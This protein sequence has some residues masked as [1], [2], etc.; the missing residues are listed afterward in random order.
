LYQNLPSATI[1]TAMVKYLF[2]FLLI[3]FIQHKAM[4]QKRTPKIVFVIADG[5]PADLIEKSHKPNFNKIIAN[6]FYKRA[7]VGGIK[8]AYNQ[9]PTV[10][11]PG[12]NNLLT[13]TWAN[14]HQVV[15]NNIKKS[16]LS[17]LFLFSIF[18]RKYPNKTDGSFFNL[19]RQ[20]N[21]INWG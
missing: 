18:K 11:A 1:F 3:S 17:V 4:A 12:Y 7:F 10:S 6:G 20:S 13:G 2:T 5:I 16:Q 21:Q 9:T 19:A 14:K 8:N 15:D